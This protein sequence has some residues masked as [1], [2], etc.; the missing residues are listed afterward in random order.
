MSSPTIT[1]AQR[2][3]WV[4]DH[5]DEMQSLHFPK[6]G[7]NPRTA[8]NDPAKL[9]AYVDGQ[10][11]ATSGWASAAPREVAEVIDAWRT[12]PL[13]SH[14]GRLFDA[15]SA[16]AEAHG[17]DLADAAGVALPRELKPKGGA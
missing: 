1:D 16:L 11:A 7:E 15:V 3:Q 4:R 12:S 5:W 6:S 8:A 10:I 2:W 17:V 13:R 9:T 14:D